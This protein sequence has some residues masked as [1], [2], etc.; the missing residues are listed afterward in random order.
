MRSRMKDVASLAGVSTATVSRAFSMPG[1]VSEEVR[2][3]IKRAAEELDYNLNAVARNLRRSDTGTVLVVVPDI[4]N[5]FFSKILKG[6]ESRARELSYSV[7]IG[8][9]AHDL[10]QIEEYARQIFTKRADGLILLNGRTPAFQSFGHAGRAIADRSKGPPI[11]AISERIPGMRLPT[12]RIDNV[13][14]AR[15]AVQ[16]LLEFRHQRIAH[17]AGPHGNILTKERLKGYLTALRA[18]GLKADREMIVHGDFSIAAGRAA[19]R[20]LL[21]SHSKPTAIFA[22][23]DEMAMGAMAELK[24]LGF[25]VPHDVSVMGFDDIEFAE[26]YDPPITTVRQPRF[27]MGRAAMSLLGQRLRGEAIKSEEIILPSELIVRD[28]TGPRK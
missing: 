4:G 12:V 27:E 9:T 17:I 24:S 16:H 5:P 18:A 6:I 20:L 13:D 10:G 28:S 8:D 19:V 22:S 21:K 3:K 23:N 26:A 25:R 14:A 1:V 11:V 2:Q 7:L 15:H